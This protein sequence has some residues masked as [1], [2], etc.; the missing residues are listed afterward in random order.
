MCEY[1]GELLSSGQA[2]QRLTAYDAQGGGH[3]LLVRH[4][5]SNRRKPTTAFL[6]YLPWRRATSTARSAMQ[7]VREILPSGN[8]SLRTTIDATQKGN[9]ARFFNHSCQP[10]LELV[11][12]RTPGQLLPRVALF[13]R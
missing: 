3:A 12:V 2:R 13:A 11:I 8:A 5:D 7:A 10:N 1:A 6:I 9:I 4:T